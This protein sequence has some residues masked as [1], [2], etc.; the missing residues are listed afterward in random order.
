MNKISKSLKAILLLGFNL[1]L[2]VPFVMWAVS[3]DNDL[4]AV[5]NRALDSQPSIPK[6]I[7]QVKQYPANFSNYYVDRFGGRAWLLKKYKKIKLFLADSP[8]PK[9]IVGKNGWLFLGETGLRVK[10]SSDPLG[11]YLRLNRYSASDLAKSSERMADISHM[12]KEKGILYVP[13]LTPN[14]HTIYP[15]YL[16]T[17]MK[18][19]AA[20]SAADQLFRV[21]GERTELPVIDLRPVLMLAK[22]KSQYPIYLQ[23]DSHWSLVGANYAQRELFSYLATVYPEYFKA[24]LYPIK[25]GNRT[26]SDLSWQVGL[27]PQRVPNPAPVFDV[28]CVPELAPSGVNYSKT[29]TTTCKDGHLKALIF[30]DSFFSALQPYVSHQ[31]KEATFLWQGLDPRKLE[32]YIEKY[33]P[34]V[35]IHEFVE[36]SL[37]YIP[38]PVPD[39]FSGGGAQNAFRRSSDVVFDSTVI[40]WKSIVAIEVDA[41]DDDKIQ[42]QSITNDPTL[43]LPNVVMNQDQEYVVNIKI[44][45]DV[46]ANLQ[47]YFTEGVNALSKFSEK[48]SIIRELSKGMNDVFI[49]L[50][51]N[52]TGPFFRLDPIDK[53]GN[54]KI[55]SM[56]IKGIY[57]RI[58]Y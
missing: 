35:V 12:L 18:P 31:F 29:F 16:P 22:D 57:T 3:N 50:P 32:G 53:V 41:V 26:W 34:D 7:K 5:D 9:V 46:K 40:D 6:T 37:P 44:S 49:S 42:Y 48:N 54:F 23:L 14:K 19:V 8:S 33:N 43:F 28:E 24:T 1:V 10:K 2:L 17:F 27:S 39:V 56:K 52:A 20:T 21:W 4:T 13:L 47:L 11:D 58:D 55:E 51:N 25:T 30:R 38:K 36:R 45:S 15:E